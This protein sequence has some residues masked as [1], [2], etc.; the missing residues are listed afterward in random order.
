[1]LLQACLNIRPKTSIHRAPLIFARDCGW[2]FKHHELPEVNVRHELTKKLTLPDQ[3]VL[4]TDSTANQTHARA[5][6]EHGLQDRQ[7]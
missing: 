6:H 2:K 4:K 3:Q 7:A 5:E 1:V